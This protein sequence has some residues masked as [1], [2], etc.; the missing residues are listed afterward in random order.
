ML[1]LICAGIAGLLVAFAIS[2]VWKI[3]LHTGVAAGIVVV[4]AELFGWPLLALA[5]GVVGIGWARVE[6]GDHTRAQVIA[7]A[8]IGAVVSG[9]TFAAVMA[10]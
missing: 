8:L 1:G 2:L 10:W 4:L 7:G 9:V 3:S 6:L 5:L